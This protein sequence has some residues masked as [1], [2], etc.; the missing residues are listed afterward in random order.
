M[1]G[2]QAGHGAGDAAADPATG[3]GAWPKDGRGGTLNPDGTPGGYYLYRAGSTI[4]GSGGL[5][6]PDLDHRAAAYG[7]KGIQFA[8][9]WHGF[10]VNADAEYGPATASAVAA[11]QRGQQKYPYVDAVRPA[12]PPGVVGKGTAYHLFAPI[13]S[14]YCA[15]YAVPPGIAHGIVELES[16]WDP[17]AVGFTTPQDLGLAQWRVPLEHDGEFMDEAKAFDVFTSLR[18]LAQTQAARYA[19]LKH[20]A[21]AMAAHH[22]PAWAA[23]W[24]KTTGAWT[25]DSPEGKSW[26]YLNVVLNHVS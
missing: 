13:A 6:A 12:D 5:A 3:R 22:A 17:G 20:W 14:A 23:Q 26:S 18:L 4:V 10:T 11:F 9:R 16:A 2:T 15:R 25:A 1:T 7:V 19:S 24:A 8:L 21:L